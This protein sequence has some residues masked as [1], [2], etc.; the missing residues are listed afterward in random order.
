MVLAD[1]GSGGRRPR[2]SSSAACSS[3]AWAERQLIGAR[4]RG[5]RR[6]GPAR[7]R[8][9]DLR[10]GAGDGAR[11][12]RPG[13]SRWL[14]VASPSASSPG[15]RVYDAD[16]P[17]AHPARGPRHA[18]RRSGSWA[19]CRGWSSAVIAGLARR[20]RRRRG[21]AC[22]AWSSSAPGPR[23]V[24]AGLGRP[25]PPAAA[26]R[27]DG[28]VRALGRWPCSPPPALLAAAIGWDA[29]ARRPDPSR[30]RCRHARS[31]CSIWVAVWL[32]GLVLAGVGRGDP[33]GRLDA[34]GDPAGHAAGA[35]RSGGRSAGLSG[36]SGASPSEGSSRPRACPGQRRASLLHCRSPRAPGAPSPMEAASP[37]MDEILDTI[38]DTIGGFFSNPIV[39]FALQAIAIYFVILWLAAAYWAFRDMQQRSE[40]PVLPYL[41]AALIILFTPGPVPVRR[42]RLP[43]HPAAREDRRGL[44]AQPR[45]GGAARRGRGDQD[46]PVV[47]PAVNEEWIICPTCRTRLNR[48]CANCGRLVGLDWSLCAWCGKDFERGDLA[49]YQPIAA[50]VPRT[51]STPTATPRPAPAPR[52][53]AARRRPASGRVAAQPGP[54]RSLDP[55]RADDRALDPRTALTSSRPR[56]ATAPTRSGPTPVHVQPRGPCRPRAVP[57]RLGR[58]PS[59]AWRSCSSR[60]S[61]DRPGGAA[62]CSSSGSCSW[63]SGCSR[64]RAPRPIEGARRTDPP[65]RGPSPVLA[66]LAVIALT[67]LVQIVVLAP[68]SRARPRRRRRRS[69]PAQ[70]RC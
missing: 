19:R 11:R 51:A 36:G 8:R 14:P 60:S 32:G 25:R 43:D 21:R 4:A 66:F 12:H 16:L 69:R 20:R 10:R 29:R 48:V 37:R 52:P 22:G 56:P 17:R 3:G 6:R 49:A 53:R 1:R 45:R 59:W 41:A 26:G 18:A 46:L 47:P 39:E 24:A 33:G 30:R 61:P 7:R 2:C 15:G 64:R 38:G 23:R 40:N 55:P 13:C 68:L 5:G 34:G 67:L 65:Y 62:G 50:P 27:P 42:H 54:S 31:P 58:R 44:R 57:R 9:S 35:A 70:P 28:A 63:A